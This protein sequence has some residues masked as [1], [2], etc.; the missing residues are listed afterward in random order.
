MQ[1]ENRENREEGVILE[2]P[3]PASQPKQP[4]QRLHWAFT[5]NNYTKSD[6]ETLETLFNQLCDKYCFQEEVGEKTGTPHLQGQ[7]SLKKAMRWSEFGLPKQIQWKKTEKLTNSYMYC[8]KAKTRAGGIFYKNYSVPEEQ[9]LELISYEEM[10][11]W[12]LVI[13]D[14]LKTKPSTRTVNW[15]WSEK[16]DVGKS[17]F[18]KY[19]VAKH[20]AI[21]IDGG[22]KGDIMHHMIT[23]KLH[24]IV[25]VDISRDEG[26]KTSYGSLESIKNGMLFSGKYE[27]G[28][29]LFNS[30]HLYVFANNPPNLKK[31]SPDR[32]N[33]I[34]ID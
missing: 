22:K 14:N 1:T 30:P 6:I 9:E 23:Q 19:L 34:N 25:V 8:C 32:W 15:Y 3:P 20:K 10:Y 13:L 21:L 4:T 33:V 2:T 16:G 29:K 27:G 5:W 11:P 24:G 7:I 18:C 12:E 31:M 17:S 26:N 28:Q